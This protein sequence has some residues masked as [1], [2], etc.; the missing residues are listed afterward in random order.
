MAAN[1]QCLLYNTTYSLHRV[2][3]LYTKY[4][5][6]T[7]NSWLSYYAQQFQNL[8]IGEV[9]RSEK[10]GAVTDK[11]AEI[12]A[13]SLKAVRWTFF[14]DKDVL[15]LEENDESSVMEY[16]CRG[17]LV[18]VS[19]EN[20]E[21]QAIFFKG[22]CSTENC[23]SE[24]IQ[25]AFLHFPLLLLKMSGP[26]RKIFLE[27][28]A[29]TFDTRISNLYLS[30]RCLIDFFERYIADLRTHEKSRER[31][32]VQ[33]S[34]DMC[35]IIKHTVVRLGFD[36]PSRS[37]L[38][39]S[40]DIQ[41]LSEDLPLMI[42]MGERAVDA[43][44]FEAFRNYLKTHLALDVN[45]PKVKIERIS[46]AAFNLSIEGKLKLAKPSNLDFHSPQIQANRR[47]IYTLVEAAKRSALSSSSYTV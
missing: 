44:F 1:S 18:T 15:G 36:L 26:L 34:E 45:N 40:I 23:G 28:F 22:L 16:A 7:E 9:L 29:T 10:T 13:G 19:Y 3:P 43:P 21:Y 14:N 11:D 37:T 39:K 20:I 47:L 46:C 27:Y 5:R 30:H 24:E 6:P 2:S 4:P 35:D 17:M 33:M 38:L 41:I 32:S 12:R 8:L 42:A 31:E 25:D